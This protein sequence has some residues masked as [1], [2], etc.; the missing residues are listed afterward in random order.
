MLAHHQDHIIALPSHDTTQRGQ[1][2]ASL[3]NFAAYEDLLAEAGRSHVRDVE[4]AADAEILPEAGPADESQGHG[5][6]KVKERGRASAVEV[7]H[8]VAVVFLDDVAKGGG[9]VRASGV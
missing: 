8:A 4:G 3:D 9:R 7:A 2:L 1:I 5:G 6:A